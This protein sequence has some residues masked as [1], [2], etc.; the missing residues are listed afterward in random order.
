VRVHKVSVSAWAGQRVAASCGIRRK[1]CYWIGTMEALSLT[2][3]I[4]CSH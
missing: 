3:S 4:A 1:L 2:G